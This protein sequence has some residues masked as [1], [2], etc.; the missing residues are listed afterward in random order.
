MILKFTKGD[1]TTRSK[2]ICTR[3]D[4][5]FTSSMMHPGVEL[6]DIIH[7]A[8]ETILEFKLGFYGILDQGYQIE[9]FEIPRHRRPLALIPSNLPIESIQAEFLVN[10]LMMETLQGPIADFMA[11]FIKALEANKIPFPDRLNETTLSEIRKLIETI[12][13]Q[14]ATIE[15]GKSM[16]LIF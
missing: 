4:G 5:S 15:E 2:L 8:V 10:Q 12:K 9:E 7:Y 16:E 11:V 1:L 14:W 6:H 13:N 3:N